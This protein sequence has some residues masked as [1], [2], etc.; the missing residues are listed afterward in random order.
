MA[1]NKLEQMLEKLVNNDRAGADELFHEFVIEKSRGIY[2][3]MLENDLED[4]EVDEAKDEE[5]DEASKDEETNEASDESSDDEETNEATDEEV[6]EATDE[7]VDEASDEDVEEAT[8]EKTDE[9]FG[10]ITPE[11][12]PMGGD[13]AD[14]M[15][16]D[17]EADADGEGDEDGD[18]EEE[19][20]DRVVDLEDALDDLKAEFE[21]MMAGDKDEDDGEADMDMDD[22]GDEDKEEAIAVP[23]E[24]SVEDEAMPFESKAKTAGEQMREYV[25]KV[26]EPKG[27]DNKAKSPVASKN[28]MGGTA[29][30]I[31]AGGEGATSG[32]AMSSKEENAGNVNVP[33]GKASKSMSN[34]KG[35]GAEKKGA[36]ETGANTKS[37]IGS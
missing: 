5:V 15:M 22:E 6:D 26:A 32:S 2:E 3:K 27:E 31:A 16:G 20:E 18:D 14:D 19:I 34:A 29:S 25:E 21:K 17:I 13:P 1:D 35:H 36:G 4:L 12:D 11:A 23:S 37:T 24:L 8:D 33:G 9:N 10:E 7:E 30:N 28:D